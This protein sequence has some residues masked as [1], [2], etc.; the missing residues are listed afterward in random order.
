VSSTFYGYQIE[1]W[2]TYVKSG[3]TT[4]DNSMDETKAAS[5]VQWCAPSGLHIQMVYEAL[6]RTI[7]TVQFYMNIE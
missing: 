3:A 7:L 5:D 1:L 4:N 6:S 2:V